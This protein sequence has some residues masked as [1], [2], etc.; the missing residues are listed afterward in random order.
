MIRGEFDAGR[1]AL[2]RAEQHDPATAGAVKHRADVLRGRIDGRAEPDAV[3]KPDAPTIEKD[4]TAH[5]SEGGQERSASGLLPNPFD[6]GHETGQ[7][8]NIHPAC[9]VCL[10]REM[11]AATADVARRRGI[12][13][14]RGSAYV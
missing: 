4:E 2:G 8:Q 11:D 12:L 3:G 13:D 6:V 14:R 1:S 9:A 7:H 10:E 5:L